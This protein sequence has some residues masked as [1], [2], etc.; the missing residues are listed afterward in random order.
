MKYLMVALLFMAGC[1]S[2]S[3]VT[4]IGSMRTDRLLFSRNFDK[5]SFKYTDPNGA[6]VEFELDKHE[7][8][9]QAVL[10]FVQNIKGEIK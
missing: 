3:V 6:I 1:T 2:T 9:I 5:A 8:D 4:P 10:D 7:S